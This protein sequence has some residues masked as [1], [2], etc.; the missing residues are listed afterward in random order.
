MIP[1]PQERRT[2]FVTAVTA[3]RRR[4]FQV[5][6]SASLLVEILLHYR[7][8]QRF[9]LH[10]FIVMPDHFH[11]LLTP[12]PDVSLEK[13]LQFIKGGFSYRLK[14]SGEVW[15]RSFNETQILTLEK[16]E[17]C[18]RYIEENPVRAS[19]SAAPT[20][21]PHSSAALVDALDPMPGHFLEA[22]SRRG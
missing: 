6:A 7:Q 12:A 18:R 19:L 17:S 21:F 16:F 8:Q 2:Y 3:N 11:A 22:T 1:A 20:E 4:I 5:D 14:S 9:L 15:E 13:A 10:A